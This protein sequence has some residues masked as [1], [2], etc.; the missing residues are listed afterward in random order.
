MLHTLLIIIHV[1]ICIVLAT[2]V[3]LQSSKGGGLAGVLADLVTGTGL[4]IEVDEE[5][6]ASC[7]PAAGPFP[8]PDLSRD[9]PEADAADEKLEGSDHPANYSDHR[10]VHAVIR[11]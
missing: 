11:F 9:F 5:K 10:A 6:M 8:A 1:I 7:E 4:G 2:V 3:L